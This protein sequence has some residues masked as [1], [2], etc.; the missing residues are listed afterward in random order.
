MSH[1]RIEEVSDSDP[2]IDDPSSYLPDTDDQIIRSVNPSTEPSRFSLPTVHST[3]NNETLFRPPPP[4]QPQS[5]SH[6][7]SRQ[8]AEASQL[9]REVVKHYQTLYPIYW[10]STRSKSQGRRVSKQLSNTKSFGMADIMC[11]TIHD[12]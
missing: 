12:W 6:V 9:R 3:G 2:E 7:Q 10:D 5:Q 4:S 1:A 8:A 11:H